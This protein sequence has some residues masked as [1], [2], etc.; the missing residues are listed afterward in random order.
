MDLFVDGLEARAVA[1]DV[2]VVDDAPPS[3]LM[4]QSAMESQEMDD[5]GGGRATFFSPLSPRVGRRECA[6]WGISRTTLAR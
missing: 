4:A 6:R 5:G 2:V 1:A 3:G